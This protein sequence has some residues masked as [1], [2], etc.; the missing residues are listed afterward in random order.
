MEPKNK[1]LVRG[2]GA[3][4]ADCVVVKRDKMSKKVSGIYAL[5]CPYTGEVRYVGQSVDIY[6][7]YKAHTSKTKRKLPVNNWCKSLADNGEKPELKILEE[8][9]NLDFAEKKWIKKYG[10]KNLLNLQPGGRCAV[11]SGSRPEGWREDDPFYVPGVKNPY[12]ILQQVWFPFRRMR[13]YKVASKKWGM[14]KKELD[15]QEGYLQFQLYACKE[16]QRLGNDAQI[17]EAEEWVIQAVKRANRLIGTSVT[18]VYND[19]IEV[20]P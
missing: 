15:S 9:I 2:V 18:L 1:K 17:K 19:G 20:T 5:C 14:L 6:R 10:L 3:N 12:L 8:T 11:Y 13:A 7:R 16:V 4:D